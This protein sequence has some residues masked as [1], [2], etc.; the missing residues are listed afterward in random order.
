MLNTLFIIPFLLIFSLCDAIPSVQKSELFLGKGVV[1]MVALVTDAQ[2][3]FMC[4]CG[5]LWD[6]SQ[7]S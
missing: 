3:I 5:D 1:C 7:C 4:P 6:K 2:S